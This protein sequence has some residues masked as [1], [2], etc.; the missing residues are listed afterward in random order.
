MSFT[1]LILI[2]FLIA[3][4]VFPFGFIYLILLAMN[5]NRR[6]NLF[7]DSFVVFVTW[8]ASSFVGVCAALAI[9]I[10][11]YTGTVIDLSLFIVVVLLG[12]IVA[13]TGVLFARR[14]ALKNS[15][16]AQGNDREIETVTVKK[17]MQTSF[18][19]SVLLLVVMV[20]MFF[21]IRD[22]K[23]RFGSNQ[24]AVVS[25]IYDTWSLSRFSF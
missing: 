7:L 13:I 23:E 2:I 17:I 11:V 24:N 12:N 25:G 3:M 9:S 22:I 5:W 21:A 6:K 14:G 4:V 16:V 10:V 19:V 15:I 18:A 20:C 1:E 8:F